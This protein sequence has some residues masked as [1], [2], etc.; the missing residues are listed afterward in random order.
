M[1]TELTK[2]YRLLVDLEGKPN[3][4]WCEIQTGKT[5]VD[6]VHFQIALERDTLEELTDE[7]STF[8]IYPPPVEPEQCEPVQP[9]P[10]LADYERAVEDV[11][12]ECA[13]AHRY[14]DIVSACSY[15]AVANP[16]Q[17]ESAAILQWRGNVWAW[18]YGLLSDPPATLP[19]LAEFRASL[20][21]A[22]P[23]P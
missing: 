9:V 22:W 15:A 11:L 6:T 17:E 21:A 2:P 3:E 4:D 7:A 13:A 1:L 5:L 12:Q 16:F 20:L 19:T 8:G 14:D 23:M 10:T 18:C